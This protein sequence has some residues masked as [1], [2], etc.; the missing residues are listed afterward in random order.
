MAESLHV[1]A[2]ISGGKDSFFSILHCMRNGHKV[3]ALA[4]LHP[5]IPAAASTNEN[6]ETTTTRGREGDEDEDGDT[7]QDLNSF[8]FQTV[9]HTVIPL[10][11]KALG[12]PLYRQPITGGAVQTGT[13]YSHAH[14]SERSESSADETES[15]VP[16][17]KRIM[18]EH[19]SANALSSGA[20]LSTYQRTRVESVALRLGLTPLSYLWKYPLLPPGTQ[21]SLL[22]D[23]Q[24][25]G[26]DARIVKVASGGLDEGFL[27]ENVASGRAVRRIE[28]A[29]A[30]FGVD[31]DGA[32]LGEGGEFETLVL[33]GP[34]C[35]F[36]ERIEVR[37][38]DWK[39]V[40]EGGG[41]A[42]L[43]VADARLVV[44]DP[45][46][47]TQE[48]CRIPDL[49]EQRFQD[50]CDTIMKEA[51]HDGL[52]SEDIEDIQPIPAY[53]LL[54]I[55]EA[56][57]DASYWTI[58]AKQPATQSIS[59]E[60]GEIIS[61]LRRRLIHASLQATDIISTTIVLRSMQDFQA[62]NQVSL[63]SSSH[64]I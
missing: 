15:L 58:T 13:S 20:I 30:R 7:E 11:E 4:N 38:G 41:S 35:L 8:M 33:D 18:K 10:Y 22:E 19:P 16:L 59:D 62:V 39:V 3:V 37:D 2:L 6:A 32:V 43:R 29:M 55:P 61:E 17:L 28:R 49:L 21:V 48:E 57:Q 5:E 51:V 25:V 27:W 50:I 24:C 31:G 9:G 54:P 14:I 36:K 53:D 63:P 42:W 47:T 12:I 56:S 26:M 45:E 52:Q 44:K 23:M 1:I 60:A 40:R 64:H 34:P 46:T